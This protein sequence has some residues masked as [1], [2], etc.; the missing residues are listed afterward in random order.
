MENEVIAAKMLSAEFVPHYRAKG[1]RFQTP[2]AR[3]NPPAARA[4]GPGPYL[5]VLTMAGYGAKMPPVN[6]RGMNKELNDAW[7]P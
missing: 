6:D 5:S 7:S 4:P 1:N 3:L 2:P